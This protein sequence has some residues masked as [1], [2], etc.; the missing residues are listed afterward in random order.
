MRRDHVL[1]L[2]L[3]DRLRF[4]RR[5]EAGWHALQ[6]EDAVAD[7]RE[8]ISKLVRE[9]AQEV[10]LALVRLHERVTLR[11]QLWPCRVSSSF[12]LCSSSLWD[13]SSSD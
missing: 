5:L 13:C 6:N 2:S 12:W 10:V 4:H 8:R 9:Y 1:R 3:D 7:R 11:A